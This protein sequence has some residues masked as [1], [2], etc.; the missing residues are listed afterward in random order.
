MLSKLQNLA[1]LL[2]QIQSFFTTFRIHSRDI[3]TLFPSMPIHIIKGIIKPFLSNK[4]L[5]YHSWKRKS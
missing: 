2:P 3:S 4:S 5:L 1:A